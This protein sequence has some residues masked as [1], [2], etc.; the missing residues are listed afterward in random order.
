MEHTNRTK[1]EEEL[2]GKLRAHPAILERIEAILTLSEE[3][4]SGPVKKADEVEALLVEQVR[5]LGNDTMRSW[6]ANAERKIGE[7]VV[8]EKS[9]AHQNGKKN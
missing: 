7:Q 3:T 1:R 9:G 4:G 2:L 5:G 6:A 8:A